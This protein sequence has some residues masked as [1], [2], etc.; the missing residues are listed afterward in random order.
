M[1]A[2][3]EE[4]QT[5]DYSICTCY[6]ECIEEGRERGRRDERRKVSKLFLINTRCSSSDAC[7]RLF[8]SY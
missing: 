1:N 7:N 3:G 6:I 4:K 2:W 5:Y 8:Y